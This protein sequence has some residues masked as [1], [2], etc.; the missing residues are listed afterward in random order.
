MKRTYAAPRLD[1]GGDVVNTTNNS[2]GLGSDS[3]T[4]Q[5]PAGSVGFLL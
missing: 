2:I 5:M 1:A 3:F 4:R